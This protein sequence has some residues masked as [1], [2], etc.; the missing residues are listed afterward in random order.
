MLARSSLVR[1]SG[2]SRRATAQAT[3]LVMLTVLAAGGC[4]GDDAAPVDAARDGQIDP[5]LDSGET[6]MDG[7]VM[8]GA[9]LD[10]FI[11]GDGAPTDALVIADAGPECGSPCTLADPCQIGAIDCT[12]D[13]PVCAAAMAAPAGTPCALGYCDG[14]GSCNADC[15]EGGPCSTGNP[16]ER[17]HVDCA[18]GAP[19]CVGD[20]PIAAGMVCRSAVGTCDVAESCNG[21][22]LACPADGFRAASFACRASTGACDPAEQCT[23]R[24]ATCPADVRRPGGL[25]RRDYPNV[26]VFLLDDLDEDTFNQML[27]E[28]LLP[29]VQR[30][31]LD[32][33]VRFRNSFV[34][35]AA[36]CP[37]RSTFL[38]GQYVQNHQVLSIGGQTGGFDRFHACTF[39]GARWN[40]AE[41]DRPNLGKWLNQPQGG[42]ADSRYFTAIVGKYLNGTRTSHPAPGQT[43]PAGAHWNYLRLLSYGGAGSGINEHSQIAGTY[44]FLTE[45]SGVV[46]P[47]GYQTYEIAEEGRQLLECGGVAER[48]GRP[49][50]VVLTPTA[51]HVSQ[52]EFPPV[53]C[54]T[55]H[56]QWT[57]RVDTD[58]G[59][60][61]TTFPVAAYRPYGCADR[62]AGCLRASGDANGSTPARPE[63]ALVS[64]SS[65]AF[66]QASPESWTSSGWC[67]LSATD[68]QNLGRLQL[69][70]MESML[71]IDLL[72]GRVMNSLGRATLDN[73]L[74]VFTSDN[75]YLLGQ[76]RIGNKMTAQ[77]ESVRVPLV[78]RPPGGLTAGRTV[79]AVALNTDLA[80]TVLDY[81][82]RDPL[83]P[84]Y[85]RGAGL[86]GRS[87]RPIVESVGS[88]R[89][90]DW[91]LL[92]H[93]LITPSEP[94]T[95][96][97]WHVPD[98]FA[99]RTFGPADQEW[100][101]VTY[102]SY[103]SSR[104]PYRQ[105]FFYDLDRDPDQERV[106][107]P[108]ADN[109]AALQWLLSILEGCRGA[110]CRAREEL[111]GDVLGQTAPWA[112]PLGPCSGGGCVLG[113]IAHDP[114]RRETMVTTAQR[115]Y[116]FR[117][118]GS[119]IASG[120]SSSL[121]RYVSAG[122]CASGAATCALDTRAFRSDMPT[123]ESLS[124]RGR[125]YNFNGDALA[126]TGRWVDVPR[127][128]AAGA[129]C[130]GAPAGCDFDTR[131]YV[132]FGGG[133]ISESIT[134]GN[135]YYNRDL[136]ASVF[137][138]GSLESVPRYR[139]GPCRYFGAGAC[140]FDARDVFVTGG[141]RI[142]RILAAGR[143][144]AF[145]DGYPL[146][147][148]PLAD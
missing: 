135:R 144:F 80:P 43:D 65:A 6:T 138:S 15:P 52:A 70:R 2:P 23:G 86:D 64:A 95:R 120:L 36:C 57:Q 34:S 105:E 107:T 126:S 24:A 130:F 119:L 1:A 121:A 48:A 145:S 123:L 116:R 25:T 109:Q 104:W 63:L 129:P 18:S 29:N 84:G 10:G 78:I 33:G 69:D 141:H 76:N 49:F 101:N 102:I 72:I 143:I 22:D 134:R 35:D 113:T 146:D 67:P 114:G 3:R 87:L 9:R 8:D 112:A 140:R 106:R 60:R 58:D 16:C 97:F 79:D 31:L 17:G 30:H 51:P 71:T 93:Y 61:G 98:Y 127:Y 74:I 46:A 118:D 90:R 131:T 27:G 148:A 81:A 94:A 75:G 108:S 28:G 44:R 11:S 54:G 137:T 83:L 21:T 73:T 89:P 136:S 139:L 38:T 32:R 100:A 88:A 62:A 40:C 47:T 142:E 20:G 55:P 42:V 14:F 4:G 117:A 13:A 128:V 115:Y 7:D 12:G 53:T 77:E 125:Y 96:A 122:I 19:R 111:R 41:R 92:E 50:F 59:R 132:D 45:G 103:D 91:I 99:V 39:D 26:L 56:P 124:A 133:R 66:G 82:G 110:E 85:N 37:S 68:R 5:R 147:D